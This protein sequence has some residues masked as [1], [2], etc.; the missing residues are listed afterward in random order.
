MRKKTRVGKHKPSTKAKQLTK[1][2]K[3][4]THELVAAA[5]AIKEREKKVN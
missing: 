1:S 4:W 3:E 2:L 5:R